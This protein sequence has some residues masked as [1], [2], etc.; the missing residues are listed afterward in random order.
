MTSEDIFALAV[1]IL[2]FWLMIAALN[3]LVSLLSSSLPVM[4]AEPMVHVGLGAG[5]AR[6]IIHFLIGVALIAFALRITRL[7]FA[8][9]R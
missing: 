8:A 5:V 2:G 6:V 3:E 9:S 4:L 7:V 1:R